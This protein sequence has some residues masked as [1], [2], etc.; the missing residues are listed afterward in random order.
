MRGFQ[1]VDFLLCTLRNFL[2]IFHV[3]LATTDGRLDWRLGEATGQQEAEEWQGNLF[4]SLAPCAQLY[5][6]SRRGTRADG[7]TLLLLPA[8]VADRPIEVGLP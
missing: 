4:S 2:G 3:P 6:Y 1:I 7:T 5:E 8:V